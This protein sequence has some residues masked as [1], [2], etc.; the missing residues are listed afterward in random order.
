ML[1]DHTQTFFFS[2]PFLVVWALMCRSSEYLEQVF[3]SPSFIH[4]HW[5][6][7][8][9]TAAHLS[10]SRCWLPSQAAF[11]WRDTGPEVA[12][13]KNKFFNPCWPCAA[14]SWLQ[15][16]LI[17]SK[18]YHSNFNYVPIHL[19]HVHL[20]LSAIYRPRWVQLK[21]LIFTRESLHYS[22]E[23]LIVT[24]NLQNGEG[25]LK[26]QMQYIIGTI[27]LQILPSAAALFTA[28]TFHYVVSFF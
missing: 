4:R 26:W 14:S 13:F 22:A 11:I 1:C 19:T 27:K 12:Y 21:T 15:G 16:H 28:A 17:Q 5:H 25:W 23:Q 20:W 18:M 3:V 7:F 10:L 2:S 8:F 24:V 9:Q 6:G